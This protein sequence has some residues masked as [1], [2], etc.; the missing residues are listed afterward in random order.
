[1]P[2]FGRRSNENLNSCHED[3]QKV[4]RE[5]VK[6]VDC[7]V[8]CGHRNE[9]DQN[10]AHHEGRSKLKFPQGKHNKLPAKAADVAPYPIDWNDK[11]RFDFFAGFVQGVASQMGI[12]IRWGG[13]WDSD[14]D[15]KDQTFNDLPHFEL[16]E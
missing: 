2:S 12:K 10:R 16:L 9:A 13:D 14:H 1:M 15:M 7:T 5:V 3:I 8:M 4:F 6:H 11:R